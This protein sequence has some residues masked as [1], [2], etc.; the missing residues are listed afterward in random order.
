MSFI[1]P[2]RTDSNGNPKA[3]G[4]MQVLGKDDFLH[5]L[6]TKLRYQNPMDPMKDE[7]FISQLAQFST[8]EQM[9]NIAEGIASSNKWDFMQMQSLNNNMAAGLIGREI[10]ASYDGVYYDQLSSPKI[11]FTTV[12]YAKEITFTV[13]DSEGKIVNTIKIEDVQ[14]GV[15]S[16]TWDGTDQSGNRVAAGYYTIEATGTKGNDMPFTP[17][18]MLTGV[19]DAISYRDGAAFLNVNGTQI[20]LGDVTWIG[21]PS[22]SADTS[23]DDDDDNNGN[24]DDDDI[25]DDVNDGND[26]NDPGN[27]T[28]DGG[29]SWDKFE[30]DNGAGA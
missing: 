13:R 12:D 4:S 10:R 26:G 25:V 27:G 16:I 3:T 9:N 24:D 1:S 28:V 22:S 29:D 6:V 8:L 20:P 5:L 21:V 11:N 19:V 23:N 15:G 14:S 17:S 2:I 7:D 30:N 18:L